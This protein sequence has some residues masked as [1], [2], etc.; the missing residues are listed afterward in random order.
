[1]NSNKINIYDNYAN[2]FR[3]LLIA[4]LLIQTQLCVASNNE[5]ETL[6]FGLL[7]SESAITKF[8]RYAPLRDYLSKKLNRNIHLETARNFPAF[9]KR[10]KEGRYDFL[11]T[12]PHFVI[13]AIDSKKY[14]VITTI[15]QPLSAQIV[16]LEKSKYLNLS[17]LAGLTIATPSP[18]AIITKLGKDTVNK[19]L[20]HAPTY[21]TYKTHNAAYESVLGH[22]SDAAI[23]SVNVFNKAIRQHIPLRVIGESNKIP[24]MSILVSTRMSRSLED[25]L[26]TTLISMKKTDTGIRVLKEISYPGYRKATAKEFNP[27]RSY[28]K[29]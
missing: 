13:P 9:I 25:K 7:P 28:L 3:A 27:I 16:V 2:R 8:K 6:I 23:I 29:Q 11:E 19:V 14:R 26:Q 1:M 18:K 21:K 5:K 20:S 17:H 24:N 4:L 22:N 15:I 10:T 12:A